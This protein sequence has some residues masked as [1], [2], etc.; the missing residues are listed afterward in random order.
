MA[1]FQT[2][3][4]LNSLLVKMLGLGST[5]YRFVENPYFRLIVAGLAGTRKITVPSQK[6][7]A[8]RMMAAGQE[9]FT[10]VCA[11]VQVS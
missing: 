10:L 6:T 2:Q 8:R 1:S 7:I 5:A 3:A 11:E 4:D 9:T